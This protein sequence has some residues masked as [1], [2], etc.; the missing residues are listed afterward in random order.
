MPWGRVPSEAGQAHQD[1][2]GEQQEADHGRDGIAGEA[3]EH[4][5]A[6]AAESQRPAGL[7]RDLPEIEAAVLLDGADDMVLVAARGA[8]RGEQDVVRSGGGGENAPDL[9]GIV[10]CN[11]EVG[12]LDRQRSQQGMEDRAVG[13]VDAA[14]NVCPAGLDEL[15]AGGQ[16][17]HA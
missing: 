10:G 6:E 1:W 9:A 3:H 4:R 7:H 13:V 2:P 16:E 17:R 5:T 8:A 14:S 11:A 12:D 15:V